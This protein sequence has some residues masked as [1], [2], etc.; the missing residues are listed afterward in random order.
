VLGEFKISS[1]DHVKRSWLETTE[2]HPKKK[3]F[4]GGPPFLF[5]TTKNE[6]PEQEKSSKEEKDLN[7]E[8]Y[9]R[10]LK[11]VEQMKKTEEK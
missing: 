1:F 5:S 2:Y 3:F 8:A 11:E 10:T 9:L 6:E 7:Y 4:G